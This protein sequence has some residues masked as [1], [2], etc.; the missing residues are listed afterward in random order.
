MVGFGTLISI[1]A[2]PTIA[3]SAAKGA[4]VGAAIL[5]VAHGAKKVIKDNGIDKAFK[6][7]FEKALNEDS[8]NKDISD[9][10]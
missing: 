9:D 1:M 2:I 5:G 8:A 3:I 6:E 7:A 10:E 4:L